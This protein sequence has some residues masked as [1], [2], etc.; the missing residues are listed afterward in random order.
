MSSY[1]ASSR[2]GDWL[3][4]LLLIRIDVLR[5]LTGSSRPIRQQEKT[6]LGN[7]KSCSG[8]F[9]EEAGYP[10]RAFFQGVARITGPLPRDACCS[11]R[12]ESSSAARSPC[13]KRGPQGARL[14]TIFAKTVPAARPIRPLAGAPAPHRRGRAGTPRRRPRQLH[15]VRLRIRES[16]GS[17][18][19]V[20]DPP[21]EA[22]LPSEEL[23]QRF[24]DDL[25]LSLNGRPEHGI[26]MILLVGSS[27]GEL[28]AVQEVRERL[29]E[30]LA[31]SSMWT[32]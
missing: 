24:A 28:A 6:G 21:L 12:L 4:G 30:E 17:G 29:K 15:R 7:S 8:I 16:G 1:R 9:S 14:V 22:R 18:R 13:S 27:C 26:G 20:G 2:S 25:K 31:Q 11:S 10:F 3:P 23:V 32:G 19:C 5:G